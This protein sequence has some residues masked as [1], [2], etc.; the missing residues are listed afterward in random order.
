MSRRKVGK[1]NGKIKQY[2][3]MREKK[4]LLIIISITLMISVISILFY[5]V[6]YGLDQIVEQL[7]R[8]SLTAVLGYFLYMDKNWAKWVLSSLMAIGGLLGLIST[9][10]LFIA[11]I[12]GFGILYI[13]MSVFYL[14]SAFYLIFYRKGSK[15]GEK[16]KVEKT[17]I[18]IPLLLWK[19]YF[20][21]FVIMM[22]LSY[23][24]LLFDS[25]WFIVDFILS[26][27][28]FIALYGYAYRKIIFPQVLFWKI[29][30][31]LFI[32]W[33]LIFELLL[34]PSYQGLSIGEIIFGLVIGTIAYF[35]IILYAFR[36]LKKV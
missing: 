34:H 31:I 6:N 2:I 18:S 12:I 26:I 36:F 17:K 5:V 32:T 16:R 4:D 22:V 3:N 30:A 35:G 13:L 24:V 8:F 9:V 20:W 7:I 15:V 29:Y 14:G 1:L 21:F 27:P 23:P 11:G 33:G 25:S 19:I 10:Q 28:G